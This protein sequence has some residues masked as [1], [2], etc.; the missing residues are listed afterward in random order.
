MASGPARSSLSTTYPT[1][2]ACFAAHAR[3]LQSGVYAPAW[4][5]RYQGNM[6]IRN[7]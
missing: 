4:Q 2:D 3:L 7:T 6:P 5:R 1:L